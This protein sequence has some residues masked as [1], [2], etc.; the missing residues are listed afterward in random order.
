MRTFLT[1][2]GV[3]VVVAAGTL[4]PA[5]AAFAF[6]DVP[7]SYWDYTAIKYV[8][9]TNTWMQD[10]GTTL[11]QPTWNETRK[12]S[13]RALVEVYAPNEPID[14]SITFPD[15]P[16]TDPFYPY[17]NVAVKLGWISKYKSGKFGPDSAFA[18]SGWDKAVVNA[19]GLQSEIAGLQK[20]HESDGDPYVVTTDFPYLQ[21]AHALQLH[22]N[23]DDETLDIQPTGLIKRDEAAYSLWKAVTVPSWLLDDAA[24]FDDIEFIGLKADAKV[25]H[26]LTQEALDQIGF[27]YIYGGEW[28]AAS[29]NGYC[30]GS[31]PQAGMDCSGFAWWVMKKYEDGYNAAAQRVYAGW[32]LPQRSSADMAQATGSHIAYADLKV[33][34]LMFFASNG[35]SNWS[36]VD[37]VGIYVGLDWMIHSAG[38]SDGPVIEWAADGYY[39]DTFVYG[40]RVIGGSLAPAPR[41]S[42]PNI[43]TDG[44]AA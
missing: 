33:G 28:N 26:N 39:Q 3:V 29:P 24:R 20:I 34:D 6:S 2:L 40:R 27:P 44:D 31:Q 19:M 23:H 36:D 17:A 10:Y 21:L 38:S 4:I 12:L 37:H 41:H 1:R 14:P 35:G 13:A 43:A 22:F 9:T 8:A 5:Q 16:A 30:C 25:K 32:T 7:T 42:Y 15:L 18:V 11:F